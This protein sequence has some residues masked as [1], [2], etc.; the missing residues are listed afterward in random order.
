MLY[1]KDILTCYYVTKENEGNTLTLKIIGQV[2]HYKHKIF[3]SIKISYLVYTEQN[4][5]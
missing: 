2:N 5:K 3:I 1:R 4:E